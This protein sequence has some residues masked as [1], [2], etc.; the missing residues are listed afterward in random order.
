MLPLV[1]LLAAALAGCAGDGGGADD[2]GGDRSGVTG[3][4][5][6]KGDGP[7]GPPM[8]VEKPEWSVGDA[9]TYSFNGADTTYVIT[10]ETA[11]D[12]IM[13]TDSA[14]RSFS[15]L[16]E[17]VSRLG[18][19]RKSDLAGSQDDE[20]VEYFRWPL[21]DGAVWSTTWDHQ[22][23]TINSLVLED[24]ADLRATDAAGNLV[25]RYSYDVANRWFTELHHYAPGGG[26]VVSLVLSKAVHNW[27]G[28]VVRWDLVQVV[29][30]KGNESLPP[31]V[32]GDFAVPEGATD[33]WADYRF[34]CTGAG[35][36]T[37]S[38]RPLGAGLA[39]QQGKLDSGPCTAQVAFTGVLADAPQAG[40]WSMAIMAGGQTVDYAYTLLV[41]TRHDVPFGA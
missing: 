14:E 36:Y 16:R 38:V 25:Y 3:V 19:Q 21:T 33:V 23:V 7:N 34:L 1:L 35:G 28:N 27:T 5:V 15:D 40:Q 37:V 8:T 31:T 9:W 10:S 26:E 22:P 24:H 32:A 13:E 30:S 17:D 39:A 20:R 2:A 11:T 4:S 41:R 12:W 29:A 18:P 6:R